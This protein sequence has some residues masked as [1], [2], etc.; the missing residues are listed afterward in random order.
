MKKILIILFIVLLIFIFK[1]KIE[2]FTIDNKYAEDNDDWIEPIVYNNII[3]EEESK[4]IID[5]V[6]DK[7]IESQI[8]SGL[9]KNIRKSQTA[10][11][12]K[13]D[14]IIYNIINKICN[15]TNYSIDNA[16]PLQIVKYES[17]GFY[18]E[19]HDACCDNNSYCE[20]FVEKSGQRAITM[21]IYLTD[22]FTDGGTFFPKL[23]KIYKP[24][25][26]GGLLFHPLSTNTSKC[27]PKAL[28]AGMPVTSGIKYIA[29]VWLRE[30]KF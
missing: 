3:T 24:N 25:K 19:H 12:N 5:N 1:N 17:D 21:V 26:C 27:H 9:N 4:Y 14:P 15:L 10:W 16:E 8:L 28:H 7:L 2:S 20:K 23:N 29:N 6:Q 22:G 11:L 18:N 13:D 30:K